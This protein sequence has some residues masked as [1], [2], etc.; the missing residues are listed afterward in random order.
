MPDFKPAYLIHGDD[1]GRIAERRS[2]LRALAESQSGAAGLELLE[3]DQATPAAAAAALSALSLTLGR[4]FVIVDGVER[5]KDSQLDLLEPLL[6]NPPPET[7]IAFF[8]R[9]DGRAEA[10]EQLHA[11]VRAAGGDISV[12]RTLSGRQLPTWVAARAAEMGLELDRAAAAELVHQVGERQQRLLRELEKLTLLVDPPASLDAERIAE[13]A[14]PSAERMLWT[15][16]DAV[17]ARDPAGALRRL[18]ELRAQGESIT[19]LVFAVARRLRDAHG[20]AERLAAGES[21]AQIKR[22]LRM[23]PKAAERLVADA[24]ASD[25]DALRRAI[26]A[27]SDLEMAT[28]GGG[29]L[30][31]DT[32]ATLAVARMAA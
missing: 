13:L 10:P 27:L 15:L 8:A 19:G 3:G 26:E 32:S 31:Q 4:R 24:G 1:H 20:V 21:P 17:V 25:R 12:E 5:W 9:E 29:A 14:A 7:T 23:P 16:G 6:K 22:S 18:L 30:E 2:R 28:R 11:L